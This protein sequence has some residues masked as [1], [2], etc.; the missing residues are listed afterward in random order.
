[1]SHLFNLLR[2]FIVSIVLIG[3]LK[4]QSILTQ[5][6]EAVNI[7]VNE[8]QDLKSISVHSTK[9]S[10]YPSK[11]VNLSLKL[12]WIPKEQRLMI[13]PNKIL[14][15]TRVPKTASMSFAFLLKD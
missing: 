11:D 9:G 14:Y 3:S 10:D 4:N 8:F 12:I 2:L 1:M 7:E 6:K 5:G 13:R 15:F